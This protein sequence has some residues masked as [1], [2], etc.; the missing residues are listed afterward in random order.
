MTGCRVGSL[1]VIWGRF[2][3]GGVWWGALGLFGVDAWGAAVVQLGP[4]SLVEIKKVI[5]K[6]W[7]SEVWL[8]WVGN[9]VGWFENVEDF[10]FFPPVVGCSLYN[11]EFWPFGVLFCVLGCFSVQLLSCARHDDGTQK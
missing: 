7:G 6:A 2:L 9:P 8:F 11:G 10:L 4:G 5:L 1:E 3:G